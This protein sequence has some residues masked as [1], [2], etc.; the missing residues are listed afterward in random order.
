MISFLHSIGWRAIPAAI[1]LVLFGFFFAPVFFHI[2]NIGNISGMI[3]STI[4]FLFNIFHHQSLSLISKFRETTVGNIVFYIISAVV[5]VLTVAVIVI[6]AFLLKAANDSP[7]TTDTT[8][9]VL[10][11]KV[12]GTLPSLMLR[13]R[14][15][16]AYVYLSEHPTVNAVVSG[17]KGDDEDISEAQCMYNYLTAKGISSNRIFMED[18][19]ES[20]YENLKFSK[21][22]IINNNLS[23]K[24]TIITDGYHQLRAEMIALSLQYSKPSN[25]SANT[26]PWLVPTYVVREWFAVAYQFAFGG[27]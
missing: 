25:I 12:K 24:I 27:K 17:G 26:S 15:D 20:T 9:I 3:L 8:V 4:I 10:G 18:K 22:I 23:G 19:S 13:R 6:S 5:L 2:L 14:L 21:N 11:C 7:K 16:A 1:S